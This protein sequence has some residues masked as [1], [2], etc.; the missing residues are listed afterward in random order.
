[1][2]MVRPLSLDPGITYEAKVARVVSVA[3]AQLLEGVDDA[4][5]LQKNLQIV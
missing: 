5:S 2:D 3:H 1:M 4:L